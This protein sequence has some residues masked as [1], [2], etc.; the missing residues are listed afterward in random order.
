MSGVMRAAEKLSMTGGHV[1][2]TSRF[3]SVAKASWVCVFNRLALSSMY[4]MGGRSGPSVIVVVGVD[5]VL[6][7]V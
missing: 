2:F 6:C 5:T 3:A 4:V 1:W 7:F